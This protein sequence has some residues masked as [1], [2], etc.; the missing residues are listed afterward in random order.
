MDLQA[1]VASADGVQEVEADRETLAEALAVGCA[2][3]F[4]CAQID[5]VLCRHLEQLAI[6]LQQQAVLLGHT[7][8]APSEIDPF[9]VEVADLLH[10]L[11]APRRGIEE[12]YDTERAAYRAV[13][14]LHE[15]FGGDHQRAPGTVRVD[16][17]IDAVVEALL[18]VVQYGPVVEVAALV[19]PCGAFGRVVHAQSVDGMGAEALLDLP[20]G[21]VGV[22][23]QVGIRCDVAGAAAVDDRAAFAAEDPRADLFETFG[24]EEVGQAE[25]REVAEQFVVGHVGLGH[26]ADLPF[27]AEE[28]FGADQFGVGP[29]AGERSG[30][31]RVVYAVVGVEHH[32]RTLDVG[33]SGDLSADLLPAAPDAALGFRCRELVVVR[34]GV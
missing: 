24:V 13:D 29:H 4:L 18:V 23:R 16:P 12:R 19:L 5:E 15:G 1:E 3:Q 6:D 22:E 33:T 20:A 34:T 26:G 21:H 7:V 9:A 30:E 14:A 32:Q 2:Q 11:S 25:R 10:P 28:L 27:V 31:L 8:E 17:V